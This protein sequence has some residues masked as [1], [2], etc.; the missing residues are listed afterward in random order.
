MPK[1]L[2]NAAQ[3]RNSFLVHLVSV[4]WAVQSDGKL[5][6]G[7]TSPE[8]LLDV[9]GTVHADSMVD[10]SDIR[11]KTDIEAMNPHERF[12][13]LEGVSYRWA[14][15]NRDQRRH[16][17]LVAYAVDALLYRGRL[18]ECARLQL[19]RVRPLGYPIVKAIKSQERAGE[20]L[21]ENAVQKDALIRSQTGRFASLEALAEKQ[22][23]E[24]LAM[25]ERLQGMPR[26][27]DAAK[28]GYDDSR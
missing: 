15:P 1:P 23:R 5:E 13:C 14:D 28:S 8:W 2:D 20:S 9:V 10:A 25:K 6:V 17:G 4:S 24:L 7:T 26:R 27:L 19:R 3:R 16:L 12:R 11:L 18:H 22:Q 21:R